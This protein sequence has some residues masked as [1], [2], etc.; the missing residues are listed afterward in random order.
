[1][2]FLIFTEGGSVSGAGHITR[3]LSFC[4][5]LS[6]KLIKTYMIVKIDNEGGEEI[7]ENTNISG[8]KI[9][10]INW[11]D[12]N[13]LKN[14]INAFNGPS[15]NSFGENSCGNA[16]E[17]NIAECK[18]HKENTTEIINVIVDSYKAGLEIYEYLCA[19]SDNRIFCDD[20]KRI[21]YPCGFVL[22][23]AVS[24]VKLNYPAEGGGVKYLLGPKYQPVREEF[25][26]TG[27]A[28][29]NKE[30]SKIVLTCGAAADAKIYSRLLI[31]LREIIPNAEI[32]IVTGKT[33]VTDD[34]IDISGNA[35]TILHSKLDASEMAALI[36]S[37]D[38]AVSACGQTLYELTLAGVPTIAFMTAENQ[39]NNAAGFMELNAIEYCGDF[40]NGGFEIKFRE[41]LNKI[42]DYDYRRKLSGRA[43][44]IIDG[45]GSA[46][47]LNE[48]FNV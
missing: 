4:S 47:C 12:I 24:A 41:A 43:R 9:E 17:K 7:L 13:I 6:S 23:G 38:A 37:C 2:K 14:Y 32:N 29:I 15:R 34:F 3:C 5:I 42:L 11:H 25:Y 18:Y 26:K 30:I 8:L 44:K 20:F 36:Y 27:R 19:V 45:K 31:P 28:A 46:R 33:P 40:E 10:K 48:V 1:M 39:R 16:G 21:K 22:N 35:K